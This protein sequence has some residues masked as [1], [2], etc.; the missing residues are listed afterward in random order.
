IQTPAATWVPAVPA[1]ALPLQSKAEFECPTQHLDA[2][3]ALLPEVTKCLV[4]GWRGKEPHFNSLLREGLKRPVKWMIAAGNTRGR[5]AIQNLQA[6]QLSGE[7]SDSNLGFSDFII[8]RTTYE[9][10]DA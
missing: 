2:L 8:Q 9:F 3:K 10:L 4:I 6:A 1:I 7:F 5:G